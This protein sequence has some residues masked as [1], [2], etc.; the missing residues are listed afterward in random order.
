MPTY[1]PIEEISEEEYLVREPQ[2]EYKSEFRDGRVVAMS[3]A[4]PTHDLIVVN[5]LAQIHHQLEKRPCRVNTGDVRVKVAAAHFYTYPDVSITCGPSQYDP[6]DRVA[7]VN[8][9][10]IIEVLSPSTQAYDRGEK[11]DYYKKLDSLREY[12]LIAQDRVRIEHFTLE[13]GRWTARE[14]LSLDEDLALDSIGCRV[15]LR[16]IYAKVEF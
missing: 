12:I 8:P 11:F 4:N 10:V 14:L 15:S 6:R 9:T 2:S 1:P 16:E 3:G 5:L 13:G 7:L